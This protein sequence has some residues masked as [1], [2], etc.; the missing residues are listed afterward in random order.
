MTNAKIFKKLI[1]GGMNRGIPF[2]FLLGLFGVELLGIW[3]L[4]YLYGH[5]TEIRP[6]GKKKGRPEGVGLENSYAGEIRSA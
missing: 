5:Y 1:R 6:K 3:L 4:T 2:L